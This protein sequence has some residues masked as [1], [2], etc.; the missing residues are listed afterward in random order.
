M[1]GGVNVMLEQLVS[2]LAVPGTLFAFAVV[3]RE[4]ANA[5]ATISKAR[6]ERKLADRRSS[7]PR[8]SK[9]R[10]RGGKADDA[11]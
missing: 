8:S 2:G 4:S 11:R 6:R 10:S 3:I 7:V 9:T 5:Y 1:G